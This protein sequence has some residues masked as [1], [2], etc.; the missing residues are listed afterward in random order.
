MTDSAA[1][2]TLTFVGGARDRDRQQDAPRHRRRAVLVDCGLFQGRKKLRLQ[3]WAPFP[4]PPDSI[5]AVVLTHAHIDHCGYIPRLVNQGFRGPIYCTDGTRKFAQIVLPDSGHLQEEEA[6]FANRHGFS[7]HEPALPLYTEAD[8]MACLDQFETVPFDDPHQVLPTVEATWHRAG[9]ILGAA[10]IGLH[11][12]DHDTRV[13][14]SGDLGRSTHPLLLPP[15]PIGRA[16]TIVTE[17]TYGDENHPDDDPEERIA[18]VVNRAARHGG[19]VLIPSFAVDRTEIVLWHLDQLVKA[20]HVPNLPIFVDSP[21]ASRALDVY[22][23]EA[24][25]GSPEIRPEF[26]GHELFSSIELTETRTVEESKGLNARR[27]PMIIISASGMATGGRIIHH[28]ASPRRRPSQR[29]PARRFPSSGNPRRGAAV[30]CPPDQIVRPLLP[31]ASQGQF[32]RAVRSR[33]PGRTDRLGA[34]R[35]TAGRHDLCQ[36]RRARQLR[37]ADRRAEQPVRPQRRRTP[38]RRTRPPG[39]PAVGSVRHTMSRIVVVG[40]INMDLGFVAL[41]LTHGHHRSL[42]LAVGA[43]DQLCWEDI[44]PGLDGLGPSDIIITQAEIPTAALDRLA[45]HAVRTHTPFFLDP[46]PPDRVSRQL[47]A[48][49]EV[50]TPDMSEAALLTGR[51]HTSQLWPELAARELLDAGAATVIVKTDEAGALLADERGVVQIATL[52]VDPGD[53]T[54]A[55]DVFLAALAVRRLEGAGWET[56]TRF[57]N[58]ASTLSFSHTGLTLPAREQVDRTVAEID[59]RTTDPSPR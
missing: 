50:I 35:H 39:S 17:S 26:H 34:D 32:D 29:G 24:R 48:S 20:G 14:F 40:G 55:G 16:D 38:P 28:L 2:P 8:A 33:R 21:M 41:E 43:N 18:E 19:V 52:P 36:S 30:R 6:D 27:G 11:L 49:T 12:T 15:A 42:V 59:G 58:A 1:A 47:L 7:K 25:D 22:R 13:A 5:D 45:T 44:E 46:T 9:H 3:N 4:V 10:S 23:A 56:A 57:A 31:G 37:R 51:N 53:E 54:G